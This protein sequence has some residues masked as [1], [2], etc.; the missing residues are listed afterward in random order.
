MTLEQAQELLAQLPGWQLDESAKTLAK[1]F[2]MKDFLSATALISA[3]AELAESEGHHPDLHLTR[4]R[5]LKIEL[6]THAVGGLTEN[7]FILAAKIEKLPKIL[8]KS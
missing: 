6:T 3:L 8:R 5:H 1:N 2:E 7:D 4:Y